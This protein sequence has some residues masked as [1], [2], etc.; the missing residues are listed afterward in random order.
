VIDVQV[1]HSWQ[2]EA[3]PVRALA[4]AVHSDPFAA[5][6]PQGNANG[7]VVHIDGLDAVASMLYR[8]YSRKQGERI[9]N[10]YGA[11]EN[12]EAMIGFAL[13]EGA[14]LQGRRRLLRQRERLSDQDCVRYAEH[15]LKMVLAITDQESRRTP[16]EMATEWRR[17]A[18]AIRRPHG[19]KQM[20]ME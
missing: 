20:Q 2:L 5:L 16:R 11:R 8:D 9:P 4:F 19:F 18:D 1:P 15:C 3:E 10:V 17:L 14:Q 7:R 13:D 6:G 12:L